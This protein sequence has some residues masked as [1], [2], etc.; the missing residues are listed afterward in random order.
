MAP[1]QYFPPSDQ[2]KNVSK[3]SS[4]YSLLKKLNILTLFSSHHADVVDPIKNTLPPKL[5]GTMTIIIEPEDISI[6]VEHLIC[7]LLKHAHSQQRFQRERESKFWLYTSNDSFNF[8]D[9]KLNNFTVFKF[10]VKKT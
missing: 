5:S 8:Q 6:S 7:T 1:L 4:K 9:K 3:R 2:L 10:N